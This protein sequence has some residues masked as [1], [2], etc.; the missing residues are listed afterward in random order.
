MFLAQ[1]QQV[2]SDKFEGDKNTNKPFIGDVISGVATG[3]LINGTMFVRNGLQ[4]YPTMYACENFIDPEY[5]DNVQTR[6]LTPV[7]PLDY[8]ALSRE[9]GKG[10]LN[11]PK[12]SNGSTAPVASKAAPKQAVV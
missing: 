4:P 3:S 11:L 2:T 10:K 8:I 5:P 7:T 6:V 12:V 1:F 9:L